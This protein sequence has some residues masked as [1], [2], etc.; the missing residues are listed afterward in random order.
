[1]L[2]TVLV[3]WAT[4]PIGITFRNKGEQS[5]MKRIA[6]QLLVGMLTFSSGIAIQRILFK[7]KPTETTPQVE[8]VETV[9]YIEVPVPASIPSPTPNLIL[10]YH[11]AKFDPYGYYTIIGKKPKGF[12]DFDSLSLEVYVDDEGVG[13]GGIYVTT[14]VEHENYDGRTAVFGLVTQQRLFFVTAPFESGFEYRFDGQFLRGSVVVDAGPRKA[15]L[16]GTLT[17]TKKGKKI[18]EC[19]VEFRVEHLGC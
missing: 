4:I 1:M 19:V 2:R 3:T 10:D 14:A 18:A 5:N 12:H 17:K 9:K 6:L 11:R 7:Q 15:V 8:R 13:S 16:R